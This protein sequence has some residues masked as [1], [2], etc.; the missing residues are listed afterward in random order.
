MPLSEHSADLLATAEAGGTAYQAPSLIYLAIMTT[1]S[2]PST[3]GTEVNGDGYAR[4]EVAPAT[5]WANDALGGL[6]ND[7]QQDWPEAAEDWGEVVEVAAF[8]AAEAGNRLWS[9]P[10][11]EGV[12]VSNGQTFYI[13]AG[14]LVRQAV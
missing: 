1:L 10:L 13:G 11:A 4:P 7:A 6:S 3:G 5:F 12:V 14:A 8:D 2:T 9:E